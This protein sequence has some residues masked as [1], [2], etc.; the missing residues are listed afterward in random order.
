LKATLQSYRIEITSAKFL[1]RMQFINALK[2]IKL[3][4]VFT[5]PP[6]LLSIYTS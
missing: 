6:K 2:P 4:T 5:K 3:K 1:I